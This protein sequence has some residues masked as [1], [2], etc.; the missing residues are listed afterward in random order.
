MPSLVI[1]HPVLG[2]LLDYW[3]QKRRG[4]AMPERRDIDPVEMGPRLLPHL[5]LCDLTERGARV[6]FRL[7]GTNVVSR[8][9]FD[10]T[11]QHLEDQPH[12]SYF[13]LLATLHR[14]SSCK[15]AP[16]YSESTFRWDRG[17]RLHVRHLVLPLSN[18]GA[19]PAISLMGGAFES[20]DAFPPQIRALNDM[21]AHSEAYRAV[22]ALP[23]IA[24]RRRIAGASV[25]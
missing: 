20:N 19:E 4:R 13:T 1:D 9:G 24:D 22:I 10:P 18:G 16:V 12:G 3:D 21:A 23:A 2:P 8:W 15:L 7:V 11:G 6:R 14:V 25:A 17:R 5:L